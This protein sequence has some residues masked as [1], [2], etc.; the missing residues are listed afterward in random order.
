MGNGIAHVFAQKGYKVNL[1]D[2]SQDSLDKALATISRNL[3][4][5]VAKE[6]IDEKAKQQALT[7]ISTHTNMTS[8]VREADLVVEAASENIDVKLKIFK[9]LDEIC[10][11]DCILASNTSSIS[12]TKIAAV[13]KRPDS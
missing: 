1:V 7:N 4:R 12:I 3:D 6:T 2:I 10:P 11:A 13:T 8:G 9:Q 5:Q